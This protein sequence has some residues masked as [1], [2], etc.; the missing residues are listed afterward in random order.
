LTKLRVS[1]LDPTLSRKLLYEVE[2]VPLTGEPA[3]KMA[4]CWGVGDDRPA[5]VMLSD[6]GVI[7]VRLQAD[8][9]VVD[10][11]IAGA[12]VLAKIERR[13]CEP[14]DAQKKLDDAL[15]LAKKS[16]RHVFVR[17]DAPW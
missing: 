3:T 11:E 15:A 13:F 4:A 14:V 16:G 7:L 9:L 8:D 6:R 1:E 10:G 12:K 2:M 5:A 17:F